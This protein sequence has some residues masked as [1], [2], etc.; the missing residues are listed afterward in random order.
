[1]NVSNLKSATKP[2]VLSLIFGGLAVGVV[3]EAQDPNSSLTR[4]M[5]NLAS[6]YRLFLTTC[7]FA[8]AAGFGAYA[9]KR[10]LWGRTPTPE[11]D[12]T[13]SSPNHP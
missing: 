10:A 2:A 12:V 1:M 11:S 6:G 7:C 9:V 5:P 13:P 8:G 4:S 3:V